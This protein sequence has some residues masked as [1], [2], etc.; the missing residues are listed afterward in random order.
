MIDT[1]LVRLY[2]ET[3]QPSEL[4]SLLE[5][6]SAISINDVEATLI[7][8]KQYSALSKLYEKAKNEAKLL[9]IWTK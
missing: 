5:S 3:E 8:H 7:Q 1:V 9:E 4:E 2:A 6:S